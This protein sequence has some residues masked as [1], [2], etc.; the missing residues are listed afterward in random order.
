MFQRQG[1]FLKGGV[2]VGHGRMAGVTGLSRQ[3]KIG[4]MQ[5]SQLRRLQ[6]C[7][8]LSMTG[9]QRQQQKESQTCRSEQQK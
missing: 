5:V 2:A 4:H 1:M 6:L 7:V 3:T 9:M 8:S